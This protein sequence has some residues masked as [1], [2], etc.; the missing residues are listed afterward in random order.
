M[1]KGLYEMH[2][3]IDG[4]FSKSYV[5]WMSRTL[6]PRGRNRGKRL[7]TDEQV[8]DLFHSHFTEEPILSI[9][10]RLGNISKTLYYAILRRDFYSDVHL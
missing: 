3:Y 8:R 6:R 5:Q 1:N 7:L 9:R 10:K 2:D 4:A